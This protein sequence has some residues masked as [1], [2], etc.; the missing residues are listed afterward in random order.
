MM[1]EHPDSDSSADRDQES[2]PRRPFTFDPKWLILLLLMVFF[3]SFLGRAWPSGPSAGF[4]TAFF[5]ALIVYKLLTRGSARRE[6]SRRLR[7]FSAFLSSLIVHK[8]I[9]QTSSGRERAQ[10]FHD[11]I[12]KRKRDEDDLPQTV[13]YREPR[14]GVGDDGEMIELPDDYED[15][16]VKHKRDAYE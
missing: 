14:I 11:E 9:P 6:R 3:W 8:L 1:W 10:R 15:E 7:F 12:E 13:R 16:P 5:A 4:F 2:A